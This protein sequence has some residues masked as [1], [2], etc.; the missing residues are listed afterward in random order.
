MYEQQG[1]RK[2]EFNAKVLCAKIEK[3]NIESWLEVARMA[4]HDDIGPKYDES[5][6][7]YN[8]ALKLMQKPKDYPKIVQTKLEKF[9]VY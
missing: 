8:R 9:W 6:R 5:K 1:E 2:F 7:Y 4:T 3:T